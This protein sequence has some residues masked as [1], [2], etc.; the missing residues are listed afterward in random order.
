M[1][2]PVRTAPE[3]DQDNLQWSSTTARVTAVTPCCGKPLV[4]VAIHAAG[5]D[6]GTTGADG[7]L[8]LA[9]PPGRHTLTAPGHSTR[10]RGVV[11]V[12]VARGGLMDATLVTSGEL[13]IFLM[14][15]SYGDCVKDGVMLCTNKSNIPDEARRFVGAA[16]APGGAT[17]PAPA[18]LGGTGGSASSAGG[19]GDREG[20]IGPAL[21]LKAGVRCTEVLSRIEARD[22]DGRRFE[23][24]E[25]LV[26]WFE[27]VGD[28][29][30]VAVLSTGAALRLGFFIGKRRTRLQSASAGAGAGRTSPGKR[31]QPKMTPATWD[32]RERA[33]TIERMK[34]EG[35]WRPS[36]VGRLLIPVTLPNSSLQKP[37]APRPSHGALGEL[38][39]RLR[40][41]GNVYA[42][43]QRRPGTAP[44]AVLSPA[45]M[46]RLA[47]LARPRGGFQALPAGDSLA[48]PLLS[49]RPRPLRT[50]MSAGAAWAKSSPQLAGGGACGSGGV[51]DRAP[52]PRLLFAAS[53][54]AAVP[55]AVVA[56]RVAA[57]PKGAAAPIAA[58]APSVQ[59]AESPTAPPLAADSADCAGLPVARV[60]ASPPTSLPASPLSTPPA[61]GQSSG[62]GRLAGGEL[63]GGWLAGGGLP[64]GGLV[65]DGPGSEAAGWYAADKLEGGSSGSSIPRGSRGLAGIGCSASPAVEAARL[66]ASD[67][68]MADFIY[69]DD[70]EGSDSEDPALTRMAPPQGVS[71]P[72]G[73]SR[74]EPSGGSRA[75]AANGAFSD[76]DDEDRF[77][78]PSRTEPSGFEEHSHMEPSVSTAGG[79]EDEVAAKPPHSD[80]HGAFEDSS[81]PA[82]ASGPEISVTASEDES[83]D[84]EG[85]VSAAGVFA[86]APLPV[87][88]AAPPEQAPSAPAQPPQATEDDEEDDDDYS[89]ED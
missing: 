77:E 66:A 84:A 59:V 70:Y 40:M 18:A 25:D 75:A 24:N 12:F 4:N 10:T 87:H 52:P 71:S 14:D 36:R 68:D 57:A 88:S 29:C 21:C 33:V 62:C 54:A 55:R 23:K 53:R 16:S 80:G 58:A 2:I 46:E 39:V 8:E 27:H 64:G 47:L 26:E 44:A 38:D 78:G 73:S 65:P 67:D 56:P 3:V 89:F 50:V 35:M 60:A 83:G 72:S 86:A 37:R 11:D 79:C 63:S 22:V 17:P 48:A 28:D 15:F 7:T 30:P 19:A 85:E 61:T 42:T 74:R 34:L 13:Y 81:G 69:D 6:V 1:F 20:A 82:A 9:L 49:R 31:G 45:Q 32:L 5:R 43:E 41:L 76:Y 51:R